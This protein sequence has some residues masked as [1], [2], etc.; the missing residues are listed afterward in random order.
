MGFSLPCLP[1]AD[2]ETSALEYVICQCFIALTGHTCDADMQ[3]I[4]ALLAH[5]GGLGLI[6]LTKLAEAEYTNSCHTSKLLS[7]KIV[8]TS[9]RNL[10]VMKRKKSANSA[11][12]QQLAT[13]AVEVRSALWSSLQWLI[14]TPTT[15]YLSSWGE[16]C[17]VIITPVINQNANN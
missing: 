17:T 8:K 5:L 15:S 3:R 6:N 14:K 12:R 7:N 10:K 2:R 16:K 9:A 1:R 11:K 4:L 13:L